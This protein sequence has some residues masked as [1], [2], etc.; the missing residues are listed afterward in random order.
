M[1]TGDDVRRAR[2]GTSRRV[3]SETVGISEAKIAGIENGRKIREDEEQKLLLFVTPADPSAPPPPPPPAAKR[4][5]KPGQPNKPKVV[6]PK[7]IGD[8]VILLDFDLENVIEMPDDLDTFDDWGAIQLAP[9]EPPAEPTPRQ[10]VPENARLVSNSEV[11]TYKRCKRKWWLSFRRGLRPQSTNPNGALR[12]GTRAHQALAEWYRPADMPR[13]DPRDALERILVE[14]WTKIEEATKDDLKR[15]T[16]AIE[17]KK[18]ADLLRA[19]IEGYVQWLAETGADEDIQVIAPEAP[20]ASEF[21][22]ESE[23]PVFITGRMD[24]RARR[25]SDG[26]RLFIDHKT[27]ADMTSPTRVLHMN[28]QMKHYHL[29]ER[30]DMGDAPGERTDGAI[31]N[32]LRKVKRSIRANPPFYQR[33]EV[34]HNDHEID[35]YERELRGVIE[36]MILTQTQIDAG[37]DT[38]VVAYPTPNDTCAWSCDFFAVCPMFDD[39]SRAENFIEN[40]FVVGDPY[41]RYPEFT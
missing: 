31:Y 33:V 34:R 35:A 1:L 22:V 7:P 18:D 23:T 27:V 37:Y 11:Q 4:G 6:L 20:M 39:G 5:R 8:D 25:L 32:M 30:L 10:L 3:F 13:T 15:E 16:Y 29:L 28:P 2:G 19:M 12:I 21:K 38:T 40:N 17:F 24:V 41:D 36:S 14:D 9:Q 26:A